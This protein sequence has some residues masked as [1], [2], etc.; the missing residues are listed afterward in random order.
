MHADNWKAIAQFI[1]LDDAERSLLDKLQ[2]KLTLND[3]ELL[4]LMIV[5]GRVAPSAARLA[6]V[7]LPKP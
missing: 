6:A 5:I 1:Q 2:T 7:R 4:R 3:E